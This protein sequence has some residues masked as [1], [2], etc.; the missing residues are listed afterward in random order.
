MRGVDATFIVDL[1]TSLQR[2]VEGLGSAGFCIRNLSMQRAAYAQFS[3]NRA[4]VSNALRA[5][6]THSALRFPNR[7]K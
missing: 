3:T 6:R 4:A 7:R 2:V 1:A 5:P